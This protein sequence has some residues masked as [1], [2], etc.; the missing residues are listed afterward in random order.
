M[1]V[2][3]ALQA[4]LLA[5]FGAAG[6]PLQPG[7]RLLEQYQAQLVSSLRCASRTAIFGTAVCWCQIAR[8]HLKH[9]T[10]PGALCISQVHAEPALT[11]SVGRCW[12]VKY[13]ELVSPCA[14]RPC[15]R[16]PR[17]T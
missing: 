11:N 6:D 13:E 12:C 2:G 3:I 16:E 8:L 17:Q 7:A 10:Q 14:G 5:R 4:A 9:M 1:T 15:S